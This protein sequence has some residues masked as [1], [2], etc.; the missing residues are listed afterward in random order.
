MGGGDIVPALLATHAPYVV[1]A[2]AL[3][4]VVRRTR[5]RIERLADHLAAL[6]GEAP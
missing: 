1:L 3:G 2:G 4:L 6:L 5:R